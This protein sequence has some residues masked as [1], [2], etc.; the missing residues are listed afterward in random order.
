MLFFLQRIQKKII[1]K[2]VA[3][4]LKVLCCRDLFLLEQVRTKYNKIKRRTACRCVGTVVL[5]FIHSFSG[6]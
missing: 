3:F 4:K 6:K 5:N 1:C 2:L